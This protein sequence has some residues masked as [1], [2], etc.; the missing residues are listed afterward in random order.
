MNLPKALLLALSCLFFAACDS[1]GAGGSES[2]FLACR[3][4]SDCKSGFVCVRRI[5]EPSDA[6]VSSGGASGSGDA[7]AGGGR[8]GAA[9][10]S[11]GNSDGGGATGGASVVSSDGGS[12]LQKDPGDAGHANATDS[13]P[14]RDG[15]ATLGCFD[16]MTGPC[17]AIARWMPTDPTGQ[18]MVYRAIPVEG[19]DAFAVLLSHGPLATADSFAFGI[20]DANGGCVEP[21]SPSWTNVAR[22]GGIRR[23]VS[24]GGT[25][26][27]VGQCVQKGLCGATFFL[28]GKEW[29]DPDG[30]TTSSFVDVDVASDG[31]VFLLDQFEGSRE[32][33]VPTVKE[34]W[35]S[36]SG[37]VLTHTFFTLRA[38]DVAILD[39]GSIAIAGG[40]DLPSGV[41]AGFVGFQPATLGS[42]SFWDPGTDRTVLAI[43]AHGPWLA[44]TGTEGG[45]SSYVWNGV[46]NAQ[47]RTEIWTRTRTDLRAMPVAVEVRADGS[48]NTAI[49]GAFGY[50]SYLL[51]HDAQNTP[52]TTT[53]PLDPNYQPNPFRPAPFGG[54]QTRTGGR[55]LFST[56]F[57]GM[58]CE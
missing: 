19:R 56:D 18:W 12:T 10:D 31:R 34:R 43:G 16:V 24:R 28:N 27:L 8:G 21:A 4:T 35:L 14:D 25:L 22:F 40:E 15:A 9:R 57:A 13:H 52:G 36:P 55:T 1:S 53:A 37:A 41:S 48:V 23:A 54:I 38:N 51:L 58:Y 11:G 44:V 45:Q 32:A 46:L 42:M 30:V 6:S 17:G 33:S 5:C 26:A 50:S 49:F 3:S 39:D 29:V 47:G 7:A 20:L 2:N